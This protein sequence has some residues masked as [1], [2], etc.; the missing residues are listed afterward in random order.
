MEFIVTGYDGD[1]DKAYERRMAVRQQHLDGLKELKDK[2]F[3][4][5]AAGIVNNED[6]LIGSMLLVQFA[7]REEMFEK[8]LNQEPYYN[9]NVWKQVKIEMARVPDF[10]K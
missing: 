6:K 1:D 2:G 7:S 4:L 8:W 5:H 3:L 10:L 9:F